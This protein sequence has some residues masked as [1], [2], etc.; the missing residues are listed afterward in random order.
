MHMQLTDD[1]RRQLLKI[2]RTSID[3]SLH[4]REFQLDEP[5]L[6]INL[7]QVCGA[8][9]TLRLDSHLRGCIGYVESENSLAATVADIAVKAAHEDPRFIPVTSRELRDIIIEISV[10]SPPRLIEDIQSIVIGVHGLYLEG[11]HHRGLLLPQVAVENNWNPETFYLQLGRKAGIH[12]FHPEYPGLK[13]FTFTA[14]VF[15]ELSVS[16]KV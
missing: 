13:I 14:D 3:D 6:T 2:A 5:G 11:E 1:E 10:L 7:T 15:N 16:E 4:D 12:D 9:V 8:F